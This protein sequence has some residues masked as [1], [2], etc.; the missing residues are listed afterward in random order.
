MKPLMVF[1]DEKGRVMDHP[2]LLLAG[3]DGP[4]AELLDAGSLIPL[5]RGSDLMMLPGR[6]PIGIDPET[7]K[8]VE[9][10]VYKGKK[11]FAAAAFLAP[12]HTQTHRAAYER[13]PGAPALPLYA[14][15]A[16]GYM[17]GRFYAAGFRVDPDRRQ[18]PWRFPYERIEAGVKKTIAAVPG[19]RLVEQLR[20]CA[21]EYCCRAAQNFFLGRW[22]APLPVS[23]VCN[24]RC[25]GCLS[26][27]KDG[28][29]RASHDRLSVAPTPEEISE[30]ALM[31]IERVDEAVVSFG[32]GCE[33]EPLLEW[34]I[35]EKSIK[36]IRKKTD[37]GTINLNTNASLP[38][39]VAA[40]VDSGLDSMRVSLNSFR[41]DLYTAYYRPSGYTLNSVL[42]SME[43]AK[44]RGC[45]I[46]VNLLVFPGV[47]DTEREL[48]AV[49]AALERIGFDMI[50]MRNLN[51]DPDVYAGVLPEGSLGKGLGVKAFM[52]R[53]SES[54]PSLAFGYFNPPK[55]RFGRR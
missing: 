30:V 6:T 55:E 19:N 50:Q 35:L 20:K 31:H 2:G 5:P 12:A 53:L 45:H 10:A 34:E 39:A 21:L 33:G 38:E 32:Q 54:F 36:S 46:A 17:K 3:M 16:V 8:A 15:T 48:G 29:F 7:G 52:N 1:C 18:D 25:A 11:V 37:K 22:E 14:Y 26:L 9:F 44:R 51:I 47:T 42:D 4:E 28:T 24:A 40:L 27:Q 49:T 43:G 23:G 13:D 41:E